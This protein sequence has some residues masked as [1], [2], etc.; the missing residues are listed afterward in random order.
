MAMFLAG[1]LIMNTLMTASA[2]GLFHGVAP[3]PRAMRF[4]M[5]LTAVYS[6][7]VGWVFLLGSSGL[8]PQLG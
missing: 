3:R 6:F 8:L 5:G 1:L 4:L 2:C 7:V